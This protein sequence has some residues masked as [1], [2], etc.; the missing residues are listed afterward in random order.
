MIIYIDK[1]CGALIQILSIWGA[2]TDISSL[3]LKAAQLGKVYPKIAFQ[4]DLQSHIRG[5]KLKK[6][7]ADKL[8]GFSKKMEPSRI[9]RLHI[10]V[11]KMVNRATFSH[12][13]RVPGIPD[14][15]SCLQA[16][17]CIRLHFAKMF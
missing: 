6:Q 2:G 4:A 3:S 5:G 15:L 9:K 12:D 7:A 8:S 10:L 14:T 1:R 11:V 13:K 17:F 16:R